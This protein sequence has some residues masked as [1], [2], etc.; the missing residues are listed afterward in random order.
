MTEIKHVEVKKV[1]DKVTVSVFCREL[2]SWADVTFEID[3]DENQPSLF[4]KVNI[5]GR[6]RHTEVTV[7]P[8][9][10]AVEDNGTTISVWCGGEASQPDG[11]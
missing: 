8:D 11:D 4:C 1:G 6:G 7:A 5:H 3:D 9:F 2:S 10:V